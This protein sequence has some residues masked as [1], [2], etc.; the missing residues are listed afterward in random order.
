MFTPIFE[1]LGRRT[2]LLPE[3]RE[4]ALGEHQAIAKGIIARDPEAARRAMD[5]HLG[6]VQAILCGES[7]EAVAREASMAEASK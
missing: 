5:T 6:K 7:R 4:T 2:G 3:A 1:R